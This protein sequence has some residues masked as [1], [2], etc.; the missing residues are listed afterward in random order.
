MNQ[1]LTTEDLSLVKKYFGVDL[2]EI[3]TD[4]FK[5]LKKAARKKYHP[6]NF[7]QFE[8]E[9]VLEMAKDRFQQVELLSGKI[10]D[11]LENQSEIDLQ[12]ERQDT[13]DP[14]AKFASEGMKIDI[15]T[16]DKSLKYLLFRSRIIYRGDKA[17]IPNTGAKIF[18]MEDY[19]SRINAGFR[20][21]IKILLAF[22]EDDSIHE[23]VHWLFTHISGRTSSFVIEGKVVKIDP[24]EIRKAIQRESILE[25]G[26]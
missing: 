3:S 13:V 19:S 25:L 8:D 9:V 16:S 23:I 17:L 14:T 24:Y 22:G 21:N 10:E 4:N 15:M 1:R 7:T 26:A 18:A 2:K 12:T 6:D 11:Y 20:E 5:D